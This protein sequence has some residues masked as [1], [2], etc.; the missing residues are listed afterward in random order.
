MNFGF[1]FYILDSKYIFVRTPDTKSAGIGQLNT[2]RI[3][4]FRYFSKTGRGASACVLYSY[5][6]FVRLSA[7]FHRS[8]FVRVSRAAVLVWEGWPATQSY[9]T[10]RL[11]LL[12]YADLT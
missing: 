1:N 7:S 8:P 10:S 2:S 4:I 9:I 12:I 11:N 5:R 3:H 6:R